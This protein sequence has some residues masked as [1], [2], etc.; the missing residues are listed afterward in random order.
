MILHEK[1]SERK[2]G[3]ELE[4]IG[5]SDDS[6]PLDHLHNSVSFQSCKSRGNSVRFDCPAEGCQNGNNSELHSLL[7]S[8]VLLQDKERGVLELKFLAQ[9]HV[10]NPSVHD[11]VRYEYL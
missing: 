6:I 11:D 3:N 8:V 4:V 1:F 9:T 2:E 5:I 7:K 10:L